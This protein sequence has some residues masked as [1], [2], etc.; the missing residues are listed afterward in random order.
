M[1]ADLRFAFRSRPKT[2]GFKLTA[3]FAHALGLGLAG[4]FACRL[5]ARKAARAN[6]PEALRSG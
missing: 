3:L 4:A 2:L 5:P 1:F 6:P